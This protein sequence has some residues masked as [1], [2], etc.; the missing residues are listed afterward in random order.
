MMMCNQIGQTALHVAALW[1]NCDA[2]RALLDLGADANVQNMT[3]STPLHFA[4]GAKN[5]A[6]EVRAQRRWACMYWQMA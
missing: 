6:R 4:A 3:G 1:G 2:L 5:H